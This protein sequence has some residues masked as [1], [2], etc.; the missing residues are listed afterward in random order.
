MRY[1]CYGLIV[2]V[3]GR[4]GITEIDMRSSYR[5][6]ADGCTTLTQLCSPVNAQCVVVYNC[7]ALTYLPECETN[8]EPIAGRL[9]VTES[10]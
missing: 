8:G 1:R 2:N 9:L 7:T 4:D 10:E 6:I 3:S 5:V